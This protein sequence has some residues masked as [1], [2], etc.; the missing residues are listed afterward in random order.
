[1]IEVGNGNGVD[2]ISDSKGRIQNN[3]QVLSRRGKLD[4]WEP[5]MK[6]FIILSR[7]S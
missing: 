4:E 1:M 3:S 5:E 2:L 7:W 6:S